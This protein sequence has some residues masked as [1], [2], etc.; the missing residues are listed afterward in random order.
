MGIFS[1]RFSEAM[2]IK[3]LTQTELS[4]IMNVNQ[5]TISRWLNGKREPDY[6]SL[7][8]LCGILDETPNYLLGYDEKEAEKNVMLAI[9]QAVLKDKGFQC[10]KNEITE[11]GKEKGKTS[12][13]IES[14][15]EKVFQQKIS[16]YREHYR[17]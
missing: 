16:E 1:E 11:S 17:F 7:M 5:T 15:V 8:L 13:E 9:E 2:R 3:K 4:K 14:E 10:L 12:Q 6:D